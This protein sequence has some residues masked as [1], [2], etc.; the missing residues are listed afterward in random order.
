[1]KFKRI[2][3]AEE[4]DAHKRYF[5]TMQNG[6]FD[7]KDVLDCI[8]QCISISKPDYYHKGV[9][10]LNDA[11]SFE[12]HHVFSDGTVSNYPNH[13]FLSD[14]GVKYENYVRY[15]NHKLYELIEGDISELKGMSIKD[16]EYWAE[17]QTMINNIKIGW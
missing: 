14:C 10:G 15:N 4:I 12:V 16:F 11:M 6:M 5:E 3:E 17:E 1:M 7:R 9:K 8:H 2:V 13:K